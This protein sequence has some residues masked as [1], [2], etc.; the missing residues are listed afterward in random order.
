MNILAPIT[1]AS[2]AVSKAY[3]DGLL[4]EYTKTANLGALASRNSLAFSELAGKPTTLAGYG[5]SNVDVSGYIK[6]GSTIQ[7]KGDLMSLTDDNQNYNWRIASIIDGAQLQVGYRDNSSNKGKFYFTGMWGEDLE[8]FFVRANGAYFDGADV[9]FRNTGKTQFAA[10]ALFQSG[11]KISAG[12]AIT[13]LDTAGTEHKL[14]YDSNNGAFKID[15]NFYTTGQNAAGEAGQSAGISQAVNNLVI[16]FHALDKL[17]ELSGSVNDAEMSAVGLTSAA[18]GNI[19]DA[20]YNKIVGA[21]TNRNVWNYT[22]YETG[23][24]IYIQLMQGDGLDILSSYSLS[25]NPSTRY[26]TILY[27]ER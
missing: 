17:I 6:G 22:A 25:R 4:A 24:G 9:Y 19:L 3:V 1:Q 12:Q 26:W 11:I 21:S 18:I 14:T 5:V 23:G 2:D 15:G 27:S 13:F 10:S 7:C 16:D 20:V 8:A